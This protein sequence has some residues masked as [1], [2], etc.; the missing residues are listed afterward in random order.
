M[1]RKKKQ[2]FCQ[3]CK[4]NIDHRRKHAIFCKPCTRK[5]QIQSRKVIPKIV[6]CK[7]CNTILGLT[8]KKY[9]DSCRIKVTRERQKISAQKTK[10][11][12][13]AYN[14]I[15]FCPICRT[16][17]KIVNC[18]VRHYTFYRRRECPQCKKRF[19]TKEVRS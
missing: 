7:R 15:A 18:D 8:K 10:I 16:R 11:K 14:N 5:R 13:N 19:S 9:C 17:T 4:T 12:V 3:I 2:R 6:R 1:G